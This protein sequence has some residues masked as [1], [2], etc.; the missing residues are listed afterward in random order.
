MAKSVHEDM[1]LGQ[2]TN[3]LSVAI[4]PTPLG[5]GGP[6][7]G[8]VVSTTKCKPG[9]WETLQAM[10]MTAWLPEKMHCTEPPTT[11]AVILAPSK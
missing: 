1:T 11:A 6:A 7:Q 3:R 4:H 2:E 9:S 5:I 10:L 8:Y